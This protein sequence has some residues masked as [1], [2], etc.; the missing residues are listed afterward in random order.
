MKKQRFGKK[1]R[2]GPAQY[3]TAAG[4]GEKEYFLPREQPIHTILLKV[5][6]HTK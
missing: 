1:D 6:K 4:S 3:H 5:L 2:A